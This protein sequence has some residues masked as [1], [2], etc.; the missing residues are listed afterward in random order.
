MWHDATSDLRTDRYVPARQSQALSLEMFKERQ[1]SF[2]LSRAF[3]TAPSIG[4][5]P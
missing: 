5:T 2:G 1:R 3:K 4:S